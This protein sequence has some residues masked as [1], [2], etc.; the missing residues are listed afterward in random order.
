MHWME[1][2]SDMDS[3]F[4]SSWAETSAWAGLYMKGQL[5]QQK[6]YILSVCEKMCFYNLL[7]WVTDL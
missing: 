2:N 7:T 3:G 1:F 6:N 5:P 4:F